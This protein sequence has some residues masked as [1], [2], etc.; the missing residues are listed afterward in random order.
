[1]KIKCYVCRHEEVEV[2][3]DEKFRKLAVPRPWE[4]PECTSALYD[5][6][7]QAVEEAC[8]LP[9]GEENEDDDIVFNSNYV[10]AVWSA[11]NDEVIL[12]D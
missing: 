12:E 4:N 11:E 2:E 7:V 10:V 3:I 8:G 5:E 9:F 6:C 1:M